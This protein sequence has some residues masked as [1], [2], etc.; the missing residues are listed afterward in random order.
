MLHKLRGTGCVLTLG[1]VPSVYCSFHSAK[2][3]TY[4][5]TFV[6][7]YAVVAVETF[8]GCHVSCVASCQYRQRAEPAW[9]PK[10]LTE[11]FNSSVDITVFNITLLWTAL[12]YI[13]S[14]NKLIKLSLIMYLKTIKI[15]FEDICH[16][17]RL[18]VAYRLTREPFINCLVI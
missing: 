16:M 7:L 5:F 3:Q 9:D 17:S 4:R 12:S 6:K 11:I 15:Y 8:S 13:F 1:I 2:Q 14:E 10:S 18:Y